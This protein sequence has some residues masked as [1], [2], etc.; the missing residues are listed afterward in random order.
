MTE[1]GMFTSNPYEGER[2]GGTVGFPL[3]GTALRIVGC[4]AMHR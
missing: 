3:P 2:R 1:G 4:Q